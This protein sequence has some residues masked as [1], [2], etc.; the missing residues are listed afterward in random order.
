MKDG[1]LTV[2]LKMALFLLIFSAVMLFIAPMGSAEWYVCMFSAI[3]MLVLII[4][5]NVAYRIRNRRDK[6]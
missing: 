6:K 4:A 2:T 5:V 1:L 3:L